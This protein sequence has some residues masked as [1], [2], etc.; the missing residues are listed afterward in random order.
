MTKNNFKFKTIVAVC[1]KNH[2]LITKLAFSL[3]KSVLVISTVKDLHIDTHNDVLR[4]NKL[5]VFFDYFFYK[6][7]TI[8]Y[9]K[10]HDV[11]LFYYEILVHI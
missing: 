7:F 10:V 2:L 5:I 3:S 4:K 6:F 1:L 11:L 9:D 8:D